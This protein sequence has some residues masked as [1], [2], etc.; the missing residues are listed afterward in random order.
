MS[1]EFDDRLA[2]AKV[3]LA[4]EVAGLSQVTIERIRDAWRPTA[5]PD[6]SD[7]PVVLDMRSVRETVLSAEERAAFDRARDE[8][9]GP[10]SLA[11]TKL[12]DDGTSLWYGVALQAVVYAARASLYG[13]AAADRLSEPMRRRLMAPWA[14]GTATSSDPNA[15]PRRPENSA[16]KQNASR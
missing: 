4:A 2:A 1:R 16:R 8:L 15:A 13:R 10:I 14:I 9:S 11:L 5:R 3:Q 7:H 6:G 12:G